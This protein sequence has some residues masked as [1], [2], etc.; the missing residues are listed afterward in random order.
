MVR[1][2]VYVSPFVRF[3]EGLGLGML[4]PDGTLVKCTLCVADVSWSVNVMVVPGATLRLLGEKFCPEPAPCGIVM[5]PV[6][7]PPLPL[8]LAPVPVEVPEP[9]EPELAGPELSEVEDDEPPAWD[10][11]ILVVLT[12]ADIVT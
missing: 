10:D 1:V 6:V 8:E 4:A 7:E 2:T 3:G 12:G 11:E 5:A 9:A